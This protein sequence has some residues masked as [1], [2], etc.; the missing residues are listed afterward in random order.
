VGAW[1]ANRSLPDR[2]VWWGVALALGLLGAA[3][4]VGG[5][6]IYFGSQMREAGDYPYTRSLADP[7]FM[8]ESHWNPYYTPIA[9]HWRM[10]ARNLGEHVSGHVPHLALSEPSAA[11]TNA[12][13]SRLGVDEA[14][15]ASLTHGFDLW[16]AYAIYAGL[17]PAIVLM[18]W[19]MLWFVALVYGSWAW[20]EAAWMTL[21]PVK[22]P[23]PLPPE[24]P[25]AGVTTYRAG[26]LFSMT[27]RR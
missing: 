24:D 25:Q 26:S 18:A 19:A 15:A 4:Q 8:S 13:T 17:P 9:G 3:V 12:E 22:V 2:R 5:V 10:L 20:R 1:F 11:A 21:R 23:K 27:D 16:P 6:A 7:L 14:Q